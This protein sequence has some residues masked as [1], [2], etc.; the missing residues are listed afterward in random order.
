MTAPSQEIV[1]DAGSSAAPAYAIEVE[2]LSV[3]YGGVRA[4]HRLSMHVPHG[5]IYGLVGPS[6][7]GKSTIIRTLATV[8]QPTAGTVLIDGVDAFVHPTVVRDRIGYLPDDTGVYRDLTVGEYLDFYA[9]IY[10]IP[11]RRRRQVG[12]E[13][14]ELIGL[15]QRRDDPVRSLPRGMTQKLGLARCLIHDPDIL[16]LDEP[17]SGMDPHSRLELRD[18]LQELA[19]FGKTILISSHLLSEL[20]AVCSHLGVIRAGEL[21]A[22][23]SVHDIVSGV[24]PDRYLRVHLLDR[25][26]GEIASR[27]IAAHGT[28]RQVEQTDSS[29][30]LATF[31]GADRDL[32]AILGQLSRSGVQVAEFT[33]ERPTLEDV[34]LHVT[35][36]EAAV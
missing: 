31:N 28:C 5:S 8:Q 12:E 26:D 23:A 18:I 3:W 25:G 10:R 14:L 2:G 16:L 17:A 20:A 29:T 13:M 34:F 11:P 22:E 24:F 7:A 19:R 9:A 4:V 30:L 35:G 36:T 21:V 6:A 27:L 15:T 32:A 1:P 33:L